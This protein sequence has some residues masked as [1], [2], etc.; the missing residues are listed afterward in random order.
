MRQWRGAFFWRDEM[1]NAILM[2]VGWLAILA[3]CIG[4]I[5]LVAERSEGGGCPEAHEVDQ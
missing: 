2:L 1:R 4:M 3:M 5:G